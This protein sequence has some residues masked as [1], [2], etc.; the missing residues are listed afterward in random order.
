MDN[1]IFATVANNIKARRTIKPST[2]N[3]NKIPNGHVASILELADWAPTHGLYRAMAF[4]R[5]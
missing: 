5:I 2:M 4:H 1:Y 3:G